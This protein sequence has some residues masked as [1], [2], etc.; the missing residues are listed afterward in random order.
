MKPPALSGEMTDG[1][2]GEAAVKCTSLSPQQPKNSHLGGI[3]YDLKGI[4]GYL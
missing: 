1:S 3:P 2:K 4:C